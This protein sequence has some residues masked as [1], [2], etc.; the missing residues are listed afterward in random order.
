MAAIPSVLK[1]DILFTDNEL[2]PSQPTAGQSDASNFELYTD[3][4]HEAPEMTESEQNKKYVLKEEKSVNSKNEDVSQIVLA[5]GIPKQDPFLET[6][7][8]N[9]GSRQDMVSPLQSSIKLDAAHVPVAV[10]SKQNNLETS[11]PSVRDI[12]STEVKTKMKQMV[13]IRF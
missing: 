6:A 3:I 8:A 5:G 7:Y 13:C 11:V 9:V 12:K 2:R 10:I 1:E 4:L